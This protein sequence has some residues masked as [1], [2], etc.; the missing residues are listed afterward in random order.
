MHAVSPQ[1]TVEDLVHDLRNGLAGVEGAI[2]IVRDA[3]S[4]RSERDILSAAIA[5]I[6]GLN[7]RLKRDEQLMSRTL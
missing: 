6:D 1:S 5:R 7:Q 2:R 3:M 4:E